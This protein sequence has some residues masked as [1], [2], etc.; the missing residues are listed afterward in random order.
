LKLPGFSIDILKYWDKSEIEKEHRLRYVMKDRNSGR[1]YFVVVLT[2]LKK[3]ADDGPLLTEQ[4]QIEKGLMKPYP[5]GNGM[6][7]YL[8]KPGGE[9]VG[10]DP[11]EAGESSAVVH[12]TK[13]APGNGT[14]KKPETPAGEQNNEKPEK[15]AGDEAKHDIHKLV[16]QEPVTETSADDVD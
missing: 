13:D 9:E 11:V 2:L 14:E 1:V 10:F 5:P 8:N 4:E 6:I 3:A 12:G 16:T 15:S 7:R